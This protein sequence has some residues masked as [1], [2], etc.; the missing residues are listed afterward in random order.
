MKIITPIEDRI[1]NNIKIIFASIIVSIIHI[2]LAT[3]VHSNSDYGGGQINVSYNVPEF[4]QMFTM[5]TT[6]CS[7]VFCIWKLAIDIKSLLKDYY[8]IKLLIDLFLLC[9]SVIYPLLFYISAHS[10]DPD[11]TYRYLASFSSVIAAFLLTRISL[12]EIKR[13]KNK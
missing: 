10:W 4:I 3:Y 1:K 6:Y 7:I 2:S 13:L 11:G 8:S 12:N 5:L 9:P